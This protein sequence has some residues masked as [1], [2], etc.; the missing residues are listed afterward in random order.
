MPFARGGGRTSRRLT[1]KY[2]VL[3]LLEE[4]EPFFFRYELCFDRQ[5][6]KGGSV[7]IRDICF[8]INKMT[9]AFIS[10]LYSGTP[11]FERNR[12]IEKGFIQC[13]VHF[14]FVF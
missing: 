3:L 4:L 10:F 14:C 2:Q 9:C 7:W 8:L 11:R 6:N 1:V 5:E 13:V 12:F